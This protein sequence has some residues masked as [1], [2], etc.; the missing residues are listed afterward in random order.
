[1]PSRNCRLIL[2]PLP[3]GVPRVTVP[4]LRLPLKPLPFGCDGGCSSVVPWTVAVHGGVAGDPVA[5]QVAASVMPD[6][7]TATEVRGLRSAKPD[8]A[9]NVSRS[10]ILKRSRVTEPPVLF[11][12][13]RR[14]ESVP[15][16]ELFAG[17]LVKSRTRFGGALEAIF[18]ST[19]RDP[20]PLL[21]WIGEER[22]CGPGAPN[23]CPPPAD[24]PLVS[25]K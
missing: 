10:M 15:N 5:R 11:T 19:K 18:A 8:A 21:R 12:H 22:F 20:K 14:I 3:S 23:R 2:P 7:T 16:V 4:A 25:T 24:V 13:R 9:G 6:T 17:S 1:M